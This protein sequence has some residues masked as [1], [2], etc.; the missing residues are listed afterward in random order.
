MI[1]PSWLHISDLHSGTDE[2][3]SG[4]IGS[5]LIDFLK[6]KKASNQFIPDIIFFSGDIANKGNGNDAQLRI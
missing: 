1:S 4:Y 2:Y 3:G 5:H 6:Q